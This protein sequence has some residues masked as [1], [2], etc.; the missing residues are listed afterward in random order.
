MFY[1]VHRNTHT[2]N[3]NEINAYQTDYKCHSNIIKTESISF[4][5]VCYIIFMHD[6]MLSDFEGYLT[7]RSKKRNRGLNS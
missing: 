6:C 5:F 7:E 4:G 2:S 3:G 1:P